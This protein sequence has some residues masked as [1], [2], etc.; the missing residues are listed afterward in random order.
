MKRAAYRLAVG[1]LLGLITPAGLAAEPSVNI[2]YAGSLEHVFLKKGNPQ[3]TGGN[4]I[5]RMDLRLNADLP[6]VQELS[7]RFQV[8]DKRP[9]MPLEDFKDGNTAL[10]AGLYH[11]ASGSRF[12]YGLL[13][14]WGFPAQL[15]NPWGRS[16]PFAENS[17]PSLADLKTAPSASGERSAYLYLGSPLLG[18]FR[19]FA[20]AQVNDAL[21]PAFGGGLN[22][23]L[24]PKTRLGFEGFST[25]KRLPPRTA[26]TWFSESPP[27]PER[28]FALY[29]LHCFLNSPQAGVAFDGAYSETFAWGS[30][31]YAGGALRLGSR[32]WQASLAVDGADSRYTD[33][34]GISPGAG[35]RTAFRFDWKE[36]RNGLS[37]AALLLR[38]PEPGERFDRCSLTLSRWFP[39]PLGFIPWKA[40]LQPAMISLGIERNAANPDQT[41]DS[42]ELALG[43][44]AGPVTVNIGA[45]LRGITE[46]TAACRF[47]S[48]K[49]SAE[50]SYS[51]GPFQFKMNLGCALGSKEP[52]WD[53][54]LSG[55][56]RFKHGRISLK[57]TAPALPGDWQYALSW[58]ISR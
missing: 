58:R 18:R 23:Q 8:I 2:L 52:V 3:D 57:I 24:A 25:A 42:A 33:R 55:A 54:S 40:P 47:D 27:L 10:S 28:D 20:S 21:V 1:I 7:A 50:L 35:F 45:A 36:R 13:D 29:G 12:L 49:T 46:D 26:S 48:A 30:G 19:L 9:L 38:A 44:D 43:L 16:A 14:E 32:P 4:F 53:A 5:N 6:R 15:R 17:R 51:P 56:A 34:R 22:I 39:R 31:F 37:R 11:K 41:R